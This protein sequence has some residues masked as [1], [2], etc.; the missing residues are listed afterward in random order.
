MSLLHGIN[1]VKIYNTGWNEITDED[2]REE[3][4]TNVPRMK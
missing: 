3:Q 2:T 1:L 4:Y